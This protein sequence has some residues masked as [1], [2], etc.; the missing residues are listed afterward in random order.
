[1]ARSGDE[2]SEETALALIAANGSS[3]NDLC[4]AASQMRDAGKGKT[5]TFSPK[6]FIPLTRLCRDFCSYCTFR[7]D[8]TEA[9]D[10]LYLTREEVLSVA[11]AGQRL[12]CTEA[13]FTLGE[14]PEV[15]YPEAKEWLAHRGYRT[16]LEYLTAMCK[17]VVEETS[18]LPLSLIHI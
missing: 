15:R 17:M 3:L 10:S 8:P 1:M 14:R 6:V 13:L 18:L 16:T 9:G 4:Y 2:L 11:R 5:V 7:Q 12:G